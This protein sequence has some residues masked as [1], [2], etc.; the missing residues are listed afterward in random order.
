M[1]VNIRRRRLAGAIAVLLPLALIALGVV[2]WHDAGT[3]PVS[4]VTVAVPL[5]ELAK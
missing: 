2:A 5:P 3:R 4:D 1:T